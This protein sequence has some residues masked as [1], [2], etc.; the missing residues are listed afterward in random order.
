M[1]EIHERSDQ[2][3]DLW[4]YKIYDAYDLI[5]RLELI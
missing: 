3:E 2:I 4:V 5:I 1:L